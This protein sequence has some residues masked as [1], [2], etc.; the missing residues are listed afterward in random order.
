MNKANLLSFIASGFSFN[1]NVSCR[2]VIKEKFSEFLTGLV[3]TIDKEMEFGNYFNKLFE[4]FLKVAKST[5]AVSSEDINL[6]CSQWN[7]E[8]PAIPDAAD[9]VD[10]IGFFLVENQELLSQYP[11]VEEF[12]ND[13]KEHGVFDLEIGVVDDNTKIA[14]GI[15]TSGLGDVYK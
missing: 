13:L 5:I 6:K 3:S 11:F 12:L 14:L 9:L 8:N 7:K 2:K 1:A 10:E 15:S 4:R